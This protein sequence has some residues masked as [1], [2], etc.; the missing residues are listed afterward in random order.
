MAHFA[1]L[2][3]N[4]E[5]LKVYVIGNDVADTEQNGINECVKLHGAG[6]YKQCSYNTSNGKHWNYN[7]FPAEESADQTKAFRKNFPGKGWIYNADIDGFISPQPY[8]S[9]T[10]NTTKGTWEAPIPE[11]ELTDPPTIYAWDEDTQSWIS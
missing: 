11:P 7:V 8:P 9:W 1:K 3:E 5:V 2:N 6:T 10:L 4:N